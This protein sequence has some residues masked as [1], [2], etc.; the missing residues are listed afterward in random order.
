M[1]I[2]LLTKTLLAWLSPP[3]RV[4]FRVN[5][6]YERPLS[7][8]C[9]ILGFFFVK[10]GHVPKAQS[11]HKWV[12]FLPNSFCLSRDNAAQRAKFARKVHK[13]P[14]VINA[15]NFELDGFN[16]FFWVPWSLSESKVSM[17]QNTWKETR[18]I[19]A[20]NLAFF[21]LATSRVQYVGLWTFLLKLAQCVPCCSFYD[22]STLGI[23]EQ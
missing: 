21:T 11:M 8:S 22:F 3:P 15:I 17:L 14:L 9:E 2:D 20:P 12:T 4:F 6:M 19:F 13:P 23:W 18:C 7:N 1:A 16:V 5:A 10:S